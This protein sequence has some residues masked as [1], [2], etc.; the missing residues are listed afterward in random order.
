MST[1][2]S[3]RWTAAPH[4]GATQP[5]IA[6]APVA[7]VSQEVIEFIRYCYQRRRIGW[8]ELYDEMC[9]VAARGEFR[10]MDYARLATMGVG[11]SLCDMNRLAALA[12]GVVFDER[13]R[14]VAIAVEGAVLP[15]DAANTAAPAV[16]SSTDIRRSDPQVMP[17]AR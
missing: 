7:D 8:P 17:L 12:Q 9:A 2:H 6:N 10:G 16:A 11:F 3:G 5:D 14:R 1:D 13:R 4:V 15:I